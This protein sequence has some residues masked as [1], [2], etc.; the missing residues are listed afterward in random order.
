MI[1]CLC[2]RLG[3]CRG[4]GLAALPLG[5]EGAGEQATDTV[6]R[7]PQSWPHQPSGYRRI[8]APNDNLGFGTTDTQLSSWGSLAK[9]GLGSGPSS[10]IYWLL[11][12]EHVTQLSLSL[13]FM[14]CETG[15]MTLTCRGAMELWMTCVQ[16]LAG[17]LPRV[18]WPS[19]HGSSHKNKCERPCGAGG[20]D[21]Y[22]IQTG[23]VTDPLSG[24][25][26]LHPIH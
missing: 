8:S 21:T 10:A 3:M 2:V 11:C 9:I 1:L 26:G 20:E 12:P 18:S 13:S 17:R 22:V 4:R 14:A 15:L 19:A 16:H 23:D 7:C 6:A 25:E 5:Q 24:Q